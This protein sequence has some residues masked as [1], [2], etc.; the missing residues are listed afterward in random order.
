MFKIMKDKGANYL[1]NLV[2]KS[3][4]LIRTRNNNI[5]TFNY[6][7]DCF[8]YSFF[9]SFLSNCF[10][11]DLNIRNAESVS[12]VKSRLLFFSFV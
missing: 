6:R 12:L 8:K 2:P 11:L 1:I 10:N 7:T 9:R 4:P 5:P 3:E